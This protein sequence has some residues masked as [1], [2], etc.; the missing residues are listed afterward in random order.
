MQ[1][2]SRLHMSIVHTF[3]DTQQIYPCEICKCVVPNIR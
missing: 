2:G 1:Q 3:Q